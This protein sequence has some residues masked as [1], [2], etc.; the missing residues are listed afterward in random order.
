[1]QGIGYNITDFPA[2]FEA[3]RFMIA[4]TVSPGKY[5]GLD[6]GYLI[7]ADIIGNAAGFFHEGN[8]DKEILW[9]TQ[10]ISQP[11]AIVELL[12][13]N[14]KTLGAVNFTGPVSISGRLMR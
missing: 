9:Y 3:V 10:Y 1:M 6:S 5:T 14:P 12:G 4:N 7:N 2:F 8:Y 13:G 11:A